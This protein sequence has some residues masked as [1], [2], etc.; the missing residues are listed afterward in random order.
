VPATDYDAMK[1]YDGL[2]KAGLIVPVGVQGAFGRNAVFESVLDG[3]N[4]AVSRLA[5]NDR[6][7]YFVFPPVIDRKVL[8]KSDYMDSFPHLSGT[9][10]SFFGKELDARKLSERIHAGEPWGDAMGI[11]D[12]TLNPAACYPVYPSFAG[13]VPPDGRLVTMLN[14]VYRHEPSPEPTRMQ[15]FR[16]REFVRCGTR[17][18]VVAWR[19]MWLERGLELLKSLGLQ[20]ASD[21]ATDPF[22]GRGGRMLAQSQRE[23]K[24]KFEVLVP[25]ISTAQPTACCSFNFHEAHFG[26]A[27]GIQTSD[28]AVANTACLG[29]GLERVAMALFQE[30]G[31]D[32]G[33]WPR[34]VREILWPA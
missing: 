34:A 20:A 6:A 17:E 9:V 18:Q 13:V 33:A 4:A 22:F 11:T 27:F 16:V 24:L 8:E 30:H 7:D 25:V 3:F 28:G 2:V 5:A 32:P 31:F 12:V 1:F 14:W 26:E 21:V 15:A 23:L 29:F 10:H 19:D